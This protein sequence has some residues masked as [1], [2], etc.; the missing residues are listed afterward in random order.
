[1][2]S[3]DLTIPSLS[4][5][6]NATAFH[7]FARLDFSPAHPPFYDTINSCIQL[8]CRVQQANRHVSIASRVSQ[9]YHL[10]IIE[11]L[12]TT[13]RFLIEESINLVSR[14]CRETYET[15]FQQNGCCEILCSRYP[16]ALWSRQL[17]CCSG[18]ERSCKS[19]TPSNPSQ[20]HFSIS[21]SSW[22][23]AIWD[24]FNYGPDCPGTR[25]IRPRSPGWS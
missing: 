17:C 25:R 19:P 7:R 5:H 9:L 18:Q 21:A 13:T 8:L 20:L 1:M 15:T 12:R 14:I 22:S 6:S 10:Q 16:E 3:S 11:S 24:P 4:H 2:C 23:Q